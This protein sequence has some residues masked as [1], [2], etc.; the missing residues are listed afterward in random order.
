[1][2]TVDTEEN[3]VE[4]IYVESID[5][6]EEWNHDLLK[7]I[8]YELRGLFGEIRTYTHFVKEVY[9]DTYAPRL[10]IN[11]SDLI[12]KVRPL[13]SYDEYRG[14]AYNA[15]LRR[16]YNEIEDIGKRIRQDIIGSQNVFITN[17]TIWNMGFMALAPIP[18]KKI[19][20]MRKE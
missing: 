8:Y 9:T 4:K 1:M 10:F 19:F 15:E 17:E 3:D 13:D 5:E 14:S 20:T 12:H 7:E 6:F 18:K 11:N 2:E 16:A